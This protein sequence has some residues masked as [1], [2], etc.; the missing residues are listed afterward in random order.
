LYLEK[1]LEAVDVSDLELLFSGFSFTV[2][3]ITCPTET[4]DELDV[5]LG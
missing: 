5:A 1:D 2:S 3:V 4:P